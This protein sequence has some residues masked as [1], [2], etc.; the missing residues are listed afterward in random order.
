MAWIKI[1]ADGST[2]ISRLVC[3]VTESNDG[4]EWSELTD[5]ELSFDAQK[6]LFIE[7]YESAFRLNFGQG[8]EVLIT[9]EESA[10]ADKFIQNLMVN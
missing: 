8:S 3:P 4:E 10:S 9:F 6:I 1:S 7:R 5:T 2:R